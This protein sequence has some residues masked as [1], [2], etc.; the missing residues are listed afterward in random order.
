M[1]TSLLK[2]TALLTLLAAAMCTTGFSNAP[3]QELV[4][5]RGLKCMHVIV[6]CHP[7][8]IGN[9]TDVRACGFANCTEAEAWAQTVIDGACDPNTEMKIQK[10]C[11]D[12]PTPFAGH[13][14]ADESPGCIHPVASCNEWI[15]EYSCLGRNG[16]T[17]VSRGVGCSYCEAWTKARTAACRLIN[18]KPFCGACRCWANV[19]QRPCCDCGPKGH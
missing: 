11:Y 16:Q 4:E 3:G 7:L 10:V 8:G 2:C 9:S 17:L 12:P 1:K 14:T 15:V 18:L 13:S 6:D 19:I 5:P